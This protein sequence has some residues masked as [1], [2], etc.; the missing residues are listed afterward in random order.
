EPG[1]CESKMG[2]TPYL[3]HD[4]SWPVDKAG[5]PMT[6]LAQVDCASLTGMTDFPQT[7]LLQFFIALD[8]TF[9]ADFDD[10]TKPDGFC[11]LYHETADPSVTAEEVQAKRPPLSEEAEKEREYYTP[12][13]SVC[14]ILFGT[15]G[16]QSLKEGDYRFEKL[17]CEK[18]NAARPEKPI[19]RIWDI[20][21]LWGELWDDDSDDEPHHQMGGYPFFTQSDP[22]E[23]GT[24]QELD[25]LLFQLDSDYDDEDLILWGDCGVANFFIS[26]EDLKKRD[27]SKTGYNWDCC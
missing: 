4:I 26:R 11:V 18:W 22:R 20:S 17:F 9:G 25:V 15:A 7:G 2:G 27:F 6:L 21:G 1:L 24:H 14:R 3:P 5:T 16:T 12:V 19:Q 13:G 8:E 23:G 10:I